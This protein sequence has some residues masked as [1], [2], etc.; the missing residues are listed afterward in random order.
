MTDLQYQAIGCGYSKVKRATGKL[1]LEDLYLILRERRLAGL[2]MWSVLV[3]QSELHVIYR[4]KQGG[5]R[6]AQADME[7]T[8]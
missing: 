7:E 8:D 3:V 5:C 2:D 6:A 1:E 4:L